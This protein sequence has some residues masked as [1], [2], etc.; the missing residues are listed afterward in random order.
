ME[1]KEKL[2]YLEQFDLLQKMKKDDII[3]MEKSM[4]MRKINKDTL[5]HFPDMQGRHVYFLKE[6]TVKIATLNPDGKELIKYLI[7]P[8]FIFGELALLES[9]EHEDDYAVALEDCIICFMDVDKLKQMMQ[10]NEDLN[11]KIRKLVG[12]R[13]KKV[14]SRLSSMF[15][16]TAPERIYDFLLEFAKEF[17]RHVKD[18][19]EAKLFL[20]QDDIAKLTAA[21]RQTVATTMNELREKGIIIYKGRYLKVLHQSTQITNHAV[22]D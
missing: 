5:L 4:V 14:E 6:G 17:G 7:R 16:K 10:M 9:Q 19:Y 8:G 3:N 15:F 13:I 20:K 11:L 22:A 21:S 12:I 18:G 1:A 2:W